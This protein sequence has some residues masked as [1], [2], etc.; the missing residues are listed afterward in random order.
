M[1]TLIIL[2][3]LFVE[4]YKMRI[5]YRKISSSALYEGKTIVFNTARTIPLVF[6]TEVFIAGIMAKHGAKVYCL[7]DNG[8]LPHI[9]TKQFSKKGLQQGTRNKKASQINQKSLSQRIQTSALLFF[10]RLAYCGNV[11]FIKYSAILDIKEINSFNI[12][13]QTK[14]QNINFRDIIESSVRRYFQTD[15]VDLGNPDQLAYF[16]FS[17]FNAIS[18]FL[19]GQYILKNLNP[20]VFITSHGIYSVWGPCFETVRKHAKI[21][22]YVYGANAYMRGTIG[23]YKEKHQILGRTKEVKDYVKLDLPND[24]RKL[25]VDYFDRRFSKKTSDTSTYYSNLVE[26]TALNNIKKPVFIAFPNLIWDGDIEERNHIFKGITQW[27]VE[28][29]EFFKNNPDKIL[30]VKFHP[31]EATLHKHTASLE[32]IIREKVPDIDQISNIKIIPAGLI[33]DTYKIINENMTIGLV[34]DGI[35]ALEIGYIGKP[36]ILCGKGRF[37]DNGLGYEPTN[38]EEYFSMLSDVN[39]LLEKWN[40][41]HCREIA[42]KFCSYYYFETNTKFP[43]YNNPKAHLGANLNCVTIEMMDLN[44]NQQLKSLFDRIILN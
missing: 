12:D 15:Q 31:A 4:Y 18:S 9:D 7:V 13:Q 23:F 40:S 8:I 43:P 29:I 20:D 21:K 30:V 37:S 27:L 17:K 14:I 35:A 6:A 38:K 32:K 1:R 19:V 28:T 36:I 39:Q 44:K 24:K 41:D 22:S 16:N 42:T 26:Y 2:F 33:V 11:N 3:K 10:S 34:Y 5:K 25:V